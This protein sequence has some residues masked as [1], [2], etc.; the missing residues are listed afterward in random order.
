MDIEQ[1]EIVDNSL[2]RCLQNPVFL[3]LFYA[4]FFAS[5]EVVREKFA[6]TD[7]EQQK[8]YLRKSLFA[9]MLGAQGSSTGNKVLE[10]V[11]KTHSKKRLDIPPDLY[12]LWRKAL[13]SSIQQ[14]DP[15]YSPEVEAAW[16]IVIDYA[17]Q[18]VVSRYE[19]GVEASDSTE[20]L[21]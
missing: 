3:D 21:H 19:D 10:S 20:Y 13:F 18:F 6:R 15:K 17:I 14:V 8:K 9:I 12:G 5:S 11:S 16:A 4:T 1:V 7:M 2:Q